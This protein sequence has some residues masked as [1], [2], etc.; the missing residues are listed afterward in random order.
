MSV[1]ITPSCL[2][3]AIESVCPRSSTVLPSSIETADRDASEHDRSAVICAV[4]NPPRGDT[5][6]LS[7]LFLDAHSVV[8]EQRR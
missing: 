6:A 7:D 3:R 4:Q 5:I 1:R 2:S 8:L